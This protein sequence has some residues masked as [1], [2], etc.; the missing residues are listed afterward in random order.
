M[1]FKAIFRRFEPLSPIEWYKL[2]PEQ[3]ITP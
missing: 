1:R 2:S 3:K